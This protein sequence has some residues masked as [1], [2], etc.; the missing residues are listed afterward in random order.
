MGIELLPEEVLGSCLVRDGLLVLLPDGG[1]ELAAELD[2]L[3]VVFDGALNPFDVGVRGI[4]DVVLDATAEEVVVFV[5]SS[6]GGALEDH[7]LDDVVFE[8]A[9][10]APD[11]ALEVVVVAD[12]TLPDPVVGVEECLHFFEELFADQCL[13]ASVVCLAFVL[14]LAEVITVAKHALHLGYRDRCGWSCGGGSRGEAAIGEFGRNVCEGVFPGRVQLEREFHE[15]CSFGVGG[16]GADFAALDS[17]QGVEV[18]DGRF[19]ERAAILGL[20]THL[21]GDVRAVF[22]G[23]VLVERR[24]DAVHQ[25]TDRGCVDRFSGGDE[26]DAA[27]LQ[28]GHDDRVIDPV[29]SEPRELVDDHVFH[30]TVVADAF[31]HL[32]ERNALGHLG[33]AAAGLDV[34]TDEGES[35]LLCLAYAGDA[36]CR[37]GDSLGVIVRVD[38]ALAGDAKVGHGP[39]AGRRIDPGEWIGLDDLCQIVLVG[40]CDH[41]AEFG[42]SRCESERRGCC[43]HGLPSFGWLSGLTLVLAGKSRPFGASRPN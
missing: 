24:Q 15:G 16:D 11:R 27:L 29:P 4:A 12:P 7:S 13:V 5:S 26:G 30:I 39:G 32:L 8:A 17:F 1:D 25:L 38:L 14:N 20:L 23:A 18:A 36:L 40:L 34:F 6:A 35:E 3:V 41:R 9:A 42:R 21:V 10:P 31:K 2:R 22:A 33:A 43:A 19:T 37:D 28:V